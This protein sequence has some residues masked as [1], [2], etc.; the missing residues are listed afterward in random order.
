MVYLQAMAQA[1]SIQ[2]SFDSARSRVELRSG[3]K[4]SDLP[5]PVEIHKLKADNR[6]FFNDALAEACKTIPQGQPVDVLMRGCQ[7]E[8]EKLEQILK[9]DLMTEA[10]K[11]IIDARKEAI[12][13]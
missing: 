2:M 7:R 1:V 3:V 12:P 4:L 5:E 9:N 6:H 11:I 10:E 13:A 8:I